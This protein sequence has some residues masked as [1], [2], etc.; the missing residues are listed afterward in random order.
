[1]PDEKYMLKVY[2]PISQQAEEVSVTEAIYLEYR[3]GGWRAENNDRRFRRHESAFS[4]LVGD[5]MGDHERFAELRCT[6]D[7]PAQMVI[8][9][10]TCENLNRIV[11]ALE[12]SEQALLQAIYAE[13]KSERRLAAELGIPQRTLHDRKVRLLRKLKKI[14]DF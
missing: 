5:E 10:L 4:D 8:D 1:M 3:R 7:E 14:L 9:H 11:S 13:G 12:T 2:N 6:D